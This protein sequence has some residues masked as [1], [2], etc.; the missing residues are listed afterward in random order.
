MSGVIHHGRTVAHSQSRTAPITN[1]YTGIR[2]EFWLGDTLNKNFQQFNII[3]I[4]VGIILNVE[5]GRVLSAQC[6]RV[7]TQTYTF[8]SIIHNNKYWI[9][10]NMMHALFAQWAGTLFNNKL[11]QPHLLV[12][13]SLSACSPHS[14]TFLFAIRLICIK[15]QFIFICANF[16]H[17]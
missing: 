14:S 10:T 17:S 3:F 8:H 6:S 9:Q 11:P 1:V 7:I 4:C 15:V 13:L 12:S 5:S 16:S 2:P